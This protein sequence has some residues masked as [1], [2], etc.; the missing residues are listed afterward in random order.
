VTQSIELPEK[1]DPQYLP[2]FLRAVHDMIAA[3]PQ[4]YR[5]ACESCEAEEW[6]FDLTDSAI[7]G[8]RC[9]VCKKCGC[10]N[11]FVLPREVAR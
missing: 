6:E 4:V 5:R 1:D 9:F 11:V 7:A 10:V 8:E 2:S 3:C